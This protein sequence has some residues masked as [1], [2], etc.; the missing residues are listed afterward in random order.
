MGTYTQTVS[1]LTK[2]ARY[3]HHAPPCT[4]CRASH[5]NF[6]SV[7]IEGGWAYLCDECRAKIGLSPYVYNGASISVAP[8]QKRRTRNERIAELF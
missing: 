3:I 8:T 2:V 7:E 6:V 1:D 5:D 4:M